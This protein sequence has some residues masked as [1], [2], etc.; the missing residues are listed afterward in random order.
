MIQFQRIF[1]RY[2]GFI[3]I[4]IMVIFK[5]LKTLF[6][7]KD[8]KR[9]AIIRIWTLGDTITCLPMIKKLKEQGYKVDIY[10]SNRSKKVIELSGL[11]DKII[12]FFP[13]FIMKPFYY[14]YVIDTEPYLNFTSIISFYMSKKAI[15][16]SNLYR[17]ILYNYK[18]KWN[19]NYHV[20]YNFARLLEPVGIKFKPDKLLPL[21]YNKKEI[22]MVNKVITRYKKM[23]L[24]GM[25][26]GMAETA[27][28]RMWKINNFK[29]LI[30]K[31]HN[32]H[33]NVIIV[34]TGSKKELKINKEIIKKLKINKIINLAGIPLGATAYLMTKLSLYISNDTG[35]MHLSAAMKCK[36]IGLFGPN[37]PKRYGPLGKN[38]ITIYKANKMKCSPCIIPYEGKFKKCPYKGKCM[39]L[40]TINDVYKKVKEILK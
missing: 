37:L 12:N 8:N 14:D 7:L 27:S 28:H 38:N 11:A 21:E 20:S 10:V 23:K 1:D 19:S 17:K 15:G 36:T 25:H 35:P 39:D 32:N 26:L 6:K 24:I 29:E 22:N 3:L 4:T 18:I 30:K 31:I 9:V 34:L 16:Y 40:I 33:K 13:A 2:I 5:P